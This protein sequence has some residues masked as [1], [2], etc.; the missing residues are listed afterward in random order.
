[1]KIKIYRGT[2]EIGGT[3]VELTA[4]NGKVLWVDLGA[5]LDKSNP[6]TSY[7]TNK[8]DAL[9]ISHS[10]QDHW[11]LM[12]SVGAD[13]PVFIGNVTLDLI[14]ATKLFLG[15]PPPNCN[16]QTFSAWED[17]LIAG[18]FKVKPY[19]V[20]HSSPEAFA[21]VIEADDQRIF[22]TGDF[23]S[24]G[25]KKK[26]FENMIAKP[27]GNINLMLTEGTMVNRSNHLYSTEEAVEHAIQEVIKNQTNITFVV[28]SAQNID[29]F[30]S[31]YRCCI[32]E[33][34]TL[35]IDIYT[36]WVL[37]EVHKV[38]PNTPTVDADNIMVYNS[39]RQLETIKGVEYDSF[40]KRVVSKS[41]ENGIFS[42]PRKYVNF[43]RC[44]NTNLVDKLLPH[45]EINL[46]YSQWEGYLKEEH[47][48]YATDPINSMVRDNKVTYQAI[49]TSG[50]ATTDDV[51]A[52]AKAINPK[53]IVP[54]HTENPKKMKD[55][56]G[57]GG[58]T[59]VEV[60]EDSKEY[61]LLNSN[62]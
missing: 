56:L 49:H 46:I 53:I 32:K 29:R 55:E 8:V 16:F 41:I 4:N 60:W 24:T 15:V 59:Q 54:I 6:D 13:V 12:E 62:L 21:F 22:Y 52:L 37:D 10:H 26:L 34:K 33:H 23:R 31:V 14:N 44:P 20:D 47:K 9:L 28:S 36:A 19:L 1:M 43:L 25:R 40:R 18:T 48:T 11:G 61:L 27:P 42:N 17:I 7:S 5:P 39:D 38:S 3:C 45:G 30:C 57:K 2:K 51:I 35:I 58:L 50:H